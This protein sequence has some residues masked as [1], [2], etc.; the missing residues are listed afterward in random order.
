MA[1]GRMPSTSRMH[2]RPHHLCPWASP[3]DDTNS[4]SSKKKHMITMAWEGEPS[5]IPYRNDLTIL[6][7]YSGCVYSKWTG[8]I[9]GKNNVGG[10]RDLQKANP[11]LLSV[12]GKSVNHRMKFHRMFVGRASGPR[13]SLTK[14]FGILKR[15]V[16]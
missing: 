12:H 8:K 11:M 1:T 16:S 10:Q 7:L 2:R 6:M 14:R 4:N 13:N 15:P 5:Y 9:C 3:S